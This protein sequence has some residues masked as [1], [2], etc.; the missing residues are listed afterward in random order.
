MS[1]FFEVSGS[2]NSYNLGEVMTHEGEVI[3]VIGVGGGVCNAV[4][5]MMR[6]G[7]KHV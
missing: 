2:E 6:S 1:H 3:K 5:N 7:V 4:D